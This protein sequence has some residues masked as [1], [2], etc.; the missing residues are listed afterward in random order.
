[1]VCYRV[2]KHICSKIPDNLALKP[3]LLNH[4]A[5]FHFDFKVMLPKTF[6]KDSFFY[7]MLLEGKDQ[8]NK[9]P[10]VANEIVIFVPLNIN[11]VLA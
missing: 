1:M 7:N 5:I 6:K 9:Q 2:R 4:S 8:N 3:K 11:S 10:Y